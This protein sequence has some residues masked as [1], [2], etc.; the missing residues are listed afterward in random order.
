MP[1]RAS[2]ALGVPVLAAI[3]LQLAYPL[4]HGTARDRITI[5]TVVVVAAA[6]IGHATLTRGRR[7]LACCVV[8]AGVGLS[9]E[10]VGVHTGVPFGDYSYSESLGWQ[11]AG[12]PIIAGLAWTMLAW[13]AALVARRLAGSA[14]MRVLIGGWALASWDLFLDPQMVAAGHWRWAH[15]DPHLP[16]VPTVPLTNFAGWLL[17]SMAISLA[18]QAILSRTAQQQDSWMFALYLWTYGSSVVGLLAFLHLQAAA[19]WGALGMGVMAGPLANRLRAGT[20]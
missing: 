7:G 6:S 12:V 16:G 19:L 18:V 15:P 20:R 14:P 1:R 11:V 9:A 17:V 13:P 8:A 10:V 5:A 3:G 2:D 4:T